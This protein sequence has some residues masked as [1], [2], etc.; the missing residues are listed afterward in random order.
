MRI[1]DSHLWFREHEGESWVA[2]GDYPSI[3]DIACFPYVMLSEDAGLSRE[4]CP[5]IRRWLDRFKRIEGFRVM[6]GVFP[7]R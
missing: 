5:S 4:E 3:A 2:C 7:A 6:S 1:L